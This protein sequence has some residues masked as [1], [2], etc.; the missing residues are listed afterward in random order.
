MERAKFAR[1]DTLVGALSCPLCFEV[2][3]SRIYLL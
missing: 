1:V 3:P 2:S